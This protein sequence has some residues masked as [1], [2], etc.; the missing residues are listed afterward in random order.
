MSFWSI[1]AWSCCCIQNFKA[2]IH[3]AWG[4]Q[5]SN[6]CKEMGYM[7][8]KQLGLHSKRGTQMCTGLAQQERLANVRNIILTFWQA[9][10]FSFSWSLGECNP[11]QSLRYQNSLYCTMIH[12]MTQNIE[13]RKKHGP[14]FASCWRQPPGSVGPQLPLQITSVALAA[15]REK[16]LL[17]LLEPFRVIIVLR[18]ESLLR[19][20]KIPYNSNHK[21]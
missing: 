9:R 13:S 17:I 11:S 3:V 2:P 7:M 8:M 16:R 19:A 21:A 4:I 15:S 1:V 18:L 14:S 20:S 6:F 12:V 10:H 5:S